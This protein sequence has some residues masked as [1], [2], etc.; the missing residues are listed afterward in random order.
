[1]VR[2]EQLLMQQKP[3]FTLV[4]GDVNSTM[5]CAITA[6]KMHV[7]VIHLEAGIRSGDWTM[8]EEINRLVTDSISNYFFTT[9]EA[10]GENLKRSGIAN[11]RI[12][13]VGN[14]MIDTLLSTETTLSN[15]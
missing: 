13:W 3:D 2:Y 15:F 14:T 6:Q 1:M 12:F 5:A 11:D 9:T 10:A 8:P 4:V 7:K